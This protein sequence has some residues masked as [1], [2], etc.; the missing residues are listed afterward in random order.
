L[1]QQLKQTALEKKY[2]IEVTDS[3]LKK[4]IGRHSQDWKKPILDHTDLFRNTAYL[5]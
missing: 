4:K 5:L 3:L 1:Q 2:W